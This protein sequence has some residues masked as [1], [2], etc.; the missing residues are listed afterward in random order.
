MRP[1]RP[2]RGDSRP[3]SCARIPVLGTIARVLL[4]SVLLPSN[5]L[6][7]LLVTHLFSER[8]RQRLLFLE[9]SLARLTHGFKMITIRRDAA[10]E[11]LQR[12]ELDAEFAR[13]LA[14][15]VAQIRGIH[16]DASTYLT[17]QGGID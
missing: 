1:S 11:L 9:L 17:A 6:S 7:F 13:S 15:V 4:V 5:M 8:I 10:S 14:H 2:D 16:V 12:S 3:G